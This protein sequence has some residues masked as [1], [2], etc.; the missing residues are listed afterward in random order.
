MASTIV[1]SLN[2]KG[3]SVVA[4]PVPIEPFI[5]SSANLF[6]KMT[7]QINDAAWELWEFEGFST[8]GE[9]AMGVSLYRD[10]RG[11]EKGGFH[12]EVNAIWPDGKKWGETLYFAEST[13]TAEGG[14]PHDG[15]VYGVWKSVDDRNDALRTIT[16]SITEDN[17]SAIVCFSVPNKVTG[18][19]ELRSSGTARKA[20]LPATEE[21]A[22]L[23]PSVYYMF[24][25]GPVTADADL[26]FT[27]VSNDGERKLYLRSNDGS[28]GG[29]VRGW[30]S[31]AWP[32]FMNDAYYVVA[33]V[34]PYMLQLLRI[35]GSAAANHKPHV[36]ARLYRDDE[37]VCSANR[38][39]NRQTRETESTTQE[40]QDVIMIEKILQGENGQEGLTGAFRDKNVGY[41]I[42][43]VS[44]QQKRWRFETRHKSAW[45]SEPTS[46]P[47]PEGT[48][49]SG[50]IETVF[51]GS[52]DE[53]FE[54]AGV[55]GQL[56]IPVP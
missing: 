27:A 46:A 53:M 11:R 48:G 23:Y 29:M 1:S 28:H 26:T 34:G 42:E 37:L 21:A 16:F 4:G 44:A 55:G 40:R 9:T 3:D 6:P 15:P 43:F 12:A 8:D 14:S 50:W 18:M 56:Q 54:G 38:V 41:V 19:I 45:W 17:S 7:S 22:L 47:G 13:M 20:R 33:N 52:D 10:A 49:K 5:P 31:K 25:M 2:I 36:A 39:V 35:V 32:Q 30:S 51:G 24:P